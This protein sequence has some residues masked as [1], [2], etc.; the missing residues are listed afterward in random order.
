MKTLFLLPGWKSNG[1]G[2]RRLRDILAGR[3]HDVEFMGYGFVLTPWKTVAYSTAIAYTLAN[4]VANDDPGET[5]LIGHSNGCNVISRASEI[6]VEMGY[7]FPEHA[8][9]ISPAL[10]RNTDSHALERIDV[11]HT[12]KDQ[13]V[14]WARWVPFSRWGDMGR[15][16]YKG[17]DPAYTNHDCTDRIW[18]HSDW[19][20]PCDINYTADRIEELL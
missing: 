1:N 16:G 10:D 18:G 3:G 19:F 9:Y 7:P 6:A 17:D 11:L 8:I 13:A 5:V 4:Q 2:V 20:D 14:R 12:K 15:V